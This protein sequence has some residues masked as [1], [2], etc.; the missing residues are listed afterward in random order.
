MDNPYAYLREQAGLGH[1]EFARDYKLNRKTLIAIETGQF[2]TLSTR[3]IDTLLG[4]C[5]DANVPTG[6]ILEER[7]DSNSLS[8]AYAKYQHAQREAFAEEIRKARVDAPAF[9]DLSPFHYFIKDS[10]GSLQGFCKKLCVPQTTVARYASGLTRTMPL[11]IESALNEIH[12]PDVDTLKERQE[13]WWSH[14]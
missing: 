8:E 2:T 9:D 5:A 3:M 10:T 11:T 6:S 7:F 14:Q 12:H 4:A 1:R 13:L